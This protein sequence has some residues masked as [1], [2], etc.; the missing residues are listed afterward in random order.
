MFRGAVS[1]ASPRPPPRPTYPT[2]RAKML[3]VAP[4]WPAGGCPTPCRSPRARERGGATVPRC[5]ARTTE[6]RSES[7][8]TGAGTARAAHSTRTGDLDVDPAPPPPPCSFQLVLLCAQARV[9]FT[10]VTTVAATRSVCATSIP[11]SHPSLAPSYPSRPHRT[12]KSIMLKTIV[13]LSLVGAASAGIHS[14]PLLENWSCKETGDCPS[15]I[16]DLCWGDCDVDSECEPG[17]VCF[18]SNTAGTKSGAVSHAGGSR[19]PGGCYSAS[20]FV[21]YNT[22]YCVDP[23]KSTTDMASDFPSL[24]DYGH[25]PMWTPSAYANGNVQRGGTRGFMPRSTTL[26]AC[27]GDCDT[28][29]DC[30]E[31]LTCFQR[32]G[33]TAVPGCSGTGINNYDCECTRARLDCPSFA[34][35]ISLTPHAR[36]C[37]CAEHTSHSAAVPFRLLTPLSTSPHLLLQTAFTQAG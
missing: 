34:P 26:G 8:A 35:H 37:S 28:N 13:T 36:W 25:D 19:M 32:D 4:C 30:R 22:D 23:A 21:T 1:V 2:R 12:S 7:F 18:Q 27:K 31:G 10:L 9:C 29:A 33:T 15:K 11:K 5:T 24:T 20:Y 14:L 6:H 16:L 17:L 3:A